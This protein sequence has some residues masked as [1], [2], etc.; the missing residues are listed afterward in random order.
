[1]AEQAL[2]VK[3]SVPVA[4]VDYNYLKNP[5]NNRRTISFSLHP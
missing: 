4:A 2:A 5:L 1:M 3:L